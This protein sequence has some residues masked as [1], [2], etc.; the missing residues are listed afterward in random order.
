M[1]FEEVLNDF[2]EH[3]REDVKVSLMLIADRDRKFQIQ[4]SLL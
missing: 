4:I 3:S 1:S 2:P